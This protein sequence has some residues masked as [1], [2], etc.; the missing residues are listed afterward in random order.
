MRPE[1]NKHN[2]TNNTS[3]TNYFHNKTNRY[4]NNL[5]GNGGGGGELGGPPCSNLSSAISFAKNN[6]HKTLRKPPKG[7]Y[8]NYEELLNLA[9]SETNETFDVLNRRLNSLKQEVTS[10]LPNIIFES[11]F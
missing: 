5:N 9:Q 11:Y 8:L 2:N 4:L 1:L 10:F 3:N 6:F 7:I